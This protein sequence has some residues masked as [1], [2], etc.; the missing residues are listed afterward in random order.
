MFKNIK[1]WL[2]CSRYYALPMTIFSWLIIFCFSLKNG[3]N[4][5][6]G[7]FALLGICC[8]HLATNLFDDYCDYKSLKKSYNNGKTILPN[9]QRGK[10]KYLLDGIATIK[11]VLIVVSIYCLISLA[12]GLTFYF[13]YGQTILLF[14]GVG[15]FI[16]LTYSFFSNIRM[17]EIM[18]GLAFGPLLFLGT[19]FV[20]T[21]KI[22]L[23]PLILSAPSSI[24]T[25]N[26]LYTDT[27]MDKDIDKNEGKKTLVNFWNTDDKALLFQIFLIAFGYISL[28]FLPI[29]NICNWRVL[30]G[31]M[32]MPLAI[33][34]INSLKSY[35]KNNKSV[36]EKKWYHFPFEYWKEIEEN[37]SPVFMF[38]MYQARNLM[39]YVSLIISISFLIY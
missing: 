9:T 19:Y 28:L 10:C 4:V 5:L 21:G 22:S 8:A 39:I 37:R 7:L 31:Y 23:Q 2:E 32:T 18:V 17:S 14:I 16:V 26:L 33:D 1:F 13:I 24:F 20:M 30:F 38:R 25:V 15:G 6:Y 36:P 29:F 35:S 34:L 12:V 3:G 27:F 11:E